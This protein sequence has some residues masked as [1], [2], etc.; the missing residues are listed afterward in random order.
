MRFPFTAQTQVDVLSV[1]EL[2]VRSKSM[3]VRSAQT[4]SSIEV[5]NVF[6]P[7]FDRFHRGEYDNTGTQ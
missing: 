4:V 5:K 7:P 3:S 1:G 2:N 6:C